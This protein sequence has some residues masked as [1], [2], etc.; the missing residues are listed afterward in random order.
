MC[1]TGKRIV[2]FGMWTISG[3]RC[4][5]RFLGPTQTFGKGSGCVG[6]GKH[7]L[8]WSPAD[9]SSRERLRAMLAWTGAWLLELAVSPG[10]ATCQLGGC[11]MQSRWAS[12][13]SVLTIKMV[14][15]A[16]T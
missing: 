2:V 4:R 6:L 12:V 16:G 11:G 1:K 10:S 15:S 9:C 7:Q 14:V 8:A 5:C 3:T 13:S